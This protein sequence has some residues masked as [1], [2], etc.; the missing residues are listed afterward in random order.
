MR[1]VWDFSIYQERR[2]KNPYWYVSSRCNKCKGKVMASWVKRNKKKYREYQK[3][4]MK[5]Y[6][7]RDAVCQ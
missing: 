5:S 4:Y 2:W 1:P 7:R 3:S 6:R